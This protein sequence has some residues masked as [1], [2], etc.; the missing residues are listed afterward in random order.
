MGR[1]ALMWLWEAWA[2]P[3]CYG[4]LDESLVRLLAGGARSDGVSGVM[5]LL[6]GAAKE[7]LLP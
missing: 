2:W 4:V 6:W 7:L 5:F 1:L 3:R